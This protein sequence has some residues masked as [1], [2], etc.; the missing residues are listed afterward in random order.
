MKDFEGTGSGTLAHDSHTGPNIYKVDREPLEDGTENPMYLVK[1]TISKIA[2]TVADNDTMA[3][4]LAEGKLH[5]VNKVVYGP[6]ILECMGGGGTLTPVDDEKGGE[7]V[8]DGNGL[9]EEPEATEK[10]AE[11]P[12]EAAEEGA[13][14]TEVAEDGEE[15]LWADDEEGDYGTSEETQPKTAPA[16]EGGAAADGLQFQNY[17][18]IGL[19][20]F[21]FTYENPTVH[22][23]EVRQAM[24]WCMDRDQLT[25]DYCGGFGIPVNGY[26]GIEQWEY[27]L[28]TGQLEY[29]VNFD[30]DVVLTPEEEEERAKHANRYARTQEEYD[31][32]IAAWELLN[33]DNLTNY[34]VYDLENDPERTEKIGIEKAKALLDSAK[35]TLNRDGEAYDP[36]KDD[37]RCKMIDGQL[38]ALDLTM[39]YPRGNHIV[40]T[41]QENWLDN[42]AEV[43]IRVTL[44]PEDMEELLKSYYREK[45]RTTDMIY[46]ATNFHVIVDP[47]I[48]YSTDPTPDHLI[49]NNTYSDDED[50]WFRAVNMRQ[51]HPEDIY[52]YV[53]KW[54]SF[55]ERYNEVLPT[56]PLYS[57][58]Y[59][60]FITNQLQNYHITAHVTWTQA[61]LESY[62]GE[63][64][65]E[66]APAEGEEGE[67]AEEDDALF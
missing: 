53:S 12:A 63:A 47:S 64:P 27:L 20:F 59:F 14:E 40:D 36:A 50:L 56:I 19:A 37:V 7:A 25:T 65:E 43:G 57:N 22:D 60:D 18:R 6:T 39:M 24:A 31:Q 49:W 42:L 35:W 21:T 67:A 33:L 29:P 52:D 11:E 8:L 61:I 5:L 55:Q 48:T 9:A 66:A 4:D 13:E 51:T 41:L 28:C 23:K 26:Y 58:I 34:N 15:D 16:G 10:A 32:M 54:I 2:F 1:P 30:L 45:E 38:V 62:F 17:P 3:Q 46:L 44:V